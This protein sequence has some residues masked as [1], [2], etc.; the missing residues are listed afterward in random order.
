MRRPQLSYANVM[1]TI[2]V[3]IAL[4]GTSYAVARN[5]VGNV[6]NSCPRSILDSIAGERPVCRPSSTRPIF[7]FS[8]MARTFGP[9][10]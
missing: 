9:M 1:S 10:A 8:R 6:G 2:A 4:G 5:S 7:F 3:F